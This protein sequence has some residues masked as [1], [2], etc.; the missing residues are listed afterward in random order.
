MYQVDFVEPSQ[1]QVHLKLIPGIDY[2]RLRGAL[3]GTQPVN[4]HNLTYNKIYI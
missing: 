2:T 3:R 1:N 4:L